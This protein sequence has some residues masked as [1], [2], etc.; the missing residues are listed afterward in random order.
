MIE[1]P[2]VSSF[3]RIV[4][5]TAFLKPEIEWHE[6]DD[7]EIIEMPETISLYEQLVVEGELELIEIPL[8]PPINEEI[9]YKPLEE[10]A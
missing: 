9:E 10:E 2:Y 7:L 4:K 5:K 3:T 6:N 8:L 1:I